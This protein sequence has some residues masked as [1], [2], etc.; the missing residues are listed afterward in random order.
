MWTA[1]AL[2]ASLLCFQQKAARAGGDACIFVSAFFFS[3]ATVR[4][5]KLAGSFPAK[6]VVMALIAAGWLGASALGQA[7]RAV[8]GPR[9]PLACLDSGHAEQPMRHLLWQ[10]PHGHVP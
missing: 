1:R 7:R 10:V 4:L 6:S 5:G 9:F 8:Q 3:L 2:Y